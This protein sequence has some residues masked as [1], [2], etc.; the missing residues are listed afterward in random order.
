M[1]GSIEV[2]S[3]QVRWVMGIEGGRFCTAVINVVRSIAS[4]DSENKRS[5]LF[6][7]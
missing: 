3:V 4:C 6:R 1:L 2:V 7:A 5:L